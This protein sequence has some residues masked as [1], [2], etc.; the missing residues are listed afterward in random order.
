MKITKNHHHSPGFYAKIDQ[1]LTQ[2]KNDIKT[3]F[4]N[5]EIFRIFKS[6]KRIL[7]YL[8]ENKILIPDESIAQ[9]I[10]EPKYYKQFYPQY[11]Y[12]E[13]ESLFTEKLLQKMKNHNPDI[14]K[15]EIESFKEKRRIGE[16]DSYICQLI[17]DDSVVEFIKFITQNNVGLSNT[18]LPSI[19]ETNSTLLQ[20]M[21][22]TLIEYSVFFGSIQI[23]QYLKINNAKLSQNMQKYAI[24]GKNAELIHILEENNNE[25]EIKNNFDSLYF[26][27]IKC[28]HIDIMNYFKNNFVDS[29][30][31]YYFFNNSYKYYNFID[32]ENNGFLPDNFRDSSFMTELCKFKYSFLVSSLLNCPDLNVIQYTIFIDFIF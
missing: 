21:K 10:S 6:H 17:R 22:T 12:P 27:S 20:N 7:L 2:I 16:N 30:M 19:F 23:F 29:E 1:I 32:I 3:N 8:L 4:T 13:F 26:E 15:M 18:I 14:F 31:I 24:H 28:H 25:N 5:S 9:A 11:F